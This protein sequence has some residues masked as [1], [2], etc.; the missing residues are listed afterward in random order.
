VFAVAIAASVAGN[1]SYAAS[2]RLTSQGMVGAAAW[3]ILLALASH[4]VI[5]TR[6]WMERRPSVAIEDIEPDTEPVSDQPKRPLT[7][8]PS[9]QVA[10]AR[11]RAGQGHK[12]ASIA[13]S[14]RERGYD[15]NDRTVARW[16]EDIRAGRARSG[17]DETDP[18]P[19]PERVA[20]P[21]T[22]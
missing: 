12:V 20:E 21:V 17:T 4:M 7:P 14:L 5:V 1:L 22:T 3:P 10:Y 16:T 8:G 11:R 18:E 19:A 15:V 13:R 6:R 9:T 2:Q